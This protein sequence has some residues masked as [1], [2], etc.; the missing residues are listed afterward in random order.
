MKILIASDA[1]HPQMNGVVR[2]LNSTI[3]ELS[4]M[5]H[6]IFVMH[7]GLF[8]TIPLPTYPEIRLALMKR[9]QISQLIED[10]TPDA[11]HITTEGTIGLGVR[12]YCV[13]RKIPFTTSY[14]TKFPEYI[15]HRFFIPEKF[16]Y[17]LMRW[18]HAK[19]EAVMVATESLKKELIDHSFD[20]IT[21]WTRG[22]D[23][24]LFNPDRPKVIHEQK[25]VLLYAG[26]LAVEKNINAF[27]ELKFDCVKYVVGIGPDLET[28][29]KKYPE[30]KFLGRKSG[31]E[32]ASYYASADVFV[33]PS[34]TDTFGL[35]MLEALSCGVP[36]AAYPV[37][38]PV[39]VIGESGVGVLNNSL[40]EA[41]AEALKIPKTKCREYALNYSWT[42]VAKIFVDNLAKI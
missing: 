39:D 37:T 32:L 1:W 16:T 20:N 41:V 33:F 2:T 25:P 34:K 31:E 15:Y 17:K 7:P 30:V 19:S 8:N 6:E 24:D 40:E 13:R 29:R 38:G 42:T 4:K 3:N 28:L 9:K 26:R 23:V 11:I 12:N 21:M 22:V 18:F 36:V 27:L 5:G 10:F 35:V 14:T